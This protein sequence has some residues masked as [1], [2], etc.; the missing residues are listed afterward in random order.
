MSQNFQKL[1]EPICIGSLELKNR[2]VMNGMH[3]G[4]EEDVYL[5]RRTI[6]FYQERANGGAA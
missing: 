1:F 2:Y 6:D 5:S 4:F 3:L